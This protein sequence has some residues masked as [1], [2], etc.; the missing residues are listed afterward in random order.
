MEAL[1]FTWE[2]KFNGSIQ[3]IPL[4]PWGVVLS[5]PPESPQVGSIPTVAPLNGPFLVGF[6]GSP[7]TRPTLS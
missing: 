3:L 6:S 7:K 4:L 2:L 5:Q 1:V